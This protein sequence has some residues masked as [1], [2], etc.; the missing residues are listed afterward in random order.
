[1][2]RLALVAASLAAVLLMAGCSDDADDA[3]DPSP[4][5]TDPPATA[6]PGPPA[7]IDFRPV[8]QTLTGAECTSHDP[9][10]VPDRHEHTCYE[11]GP[12]AVDATAIESATAGL[13]AT[14]ENWLVF[15]VFRVGD[16]GIDS[17]NEAAAR[18]FQAGPTCPNRALAIVVGAEVVSAPVLQQPSYE[19]DQIQ[20]TGDFSQEEAEALAEELSP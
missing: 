13:D 9:E 2:R 15:P 18:C 6:P 7:D 1:M 3:S 12:S 17:F 8:L 5:T 10:V 4:I 11:L 14:G 16:P 19:R 20:I